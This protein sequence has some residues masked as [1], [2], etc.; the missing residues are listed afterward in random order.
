MQWS[1]KHLAAI[2]LSVSI[3][4]GLVIWLLPI[5]QGLSVAAWRLFAIFFA[6][7]ICIILNCLLNPQIR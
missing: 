3:L 4:L 2:K 5:P 1:E 6:T 7:I